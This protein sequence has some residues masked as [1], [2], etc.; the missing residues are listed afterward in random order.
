[1]CCSSWGHKELEM[2][3]QLNGTELNR[4]PHYIQSVFVD[5]IF[6]YMDVY[7]LIRIS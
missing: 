5:D 2:T 1:M 7:M 3:E 4:V 6:L